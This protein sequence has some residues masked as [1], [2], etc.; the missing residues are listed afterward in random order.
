M[1]SDSDVIRIS[2]LASLDNKSFMRIRTSRPTRSE[3]SEVRENEQWRCFPPPR[4]SSSELCSRSDR[5]SEGV[6]RSARAHG[7]R[8]THRRRLPGGMPPP[9]VVVV[10][11]ICSRGCPDMLCV[12]VPSRLKNPD[13]FETILP[14]KGYHRAS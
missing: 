3:T 6:T 9:L 5:L 7:R 1:E 12:S 4:L 10:G 11:R 13:S 14:T 2:H 8:G